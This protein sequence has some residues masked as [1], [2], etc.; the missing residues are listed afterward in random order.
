MYYQINPTETFRER[1]LAL[2]GEAEDWRR[3]RRRLRAPRARASCRPQT[4]RKE[5]EMTQAID[6]RTS[7][8]GW[9]RKTLLGACLMVVA[10]LLAAC[11]MG[12]QPAHASTT[13][14]VNSTGDDADVGPL[15]NVCDASRGGGECTLRAA[16]QQANA[17]S[18]AD[19]INFDIP[20]TGVQTIHVNATGFGA[21][22]AITEQVT[23]DG[24]T[25]AG[26]HPNT[27]AVGNDAALKIV[28]D[29]T[30][31]GGDGLRID[32]ASNSLIKGLVINS[33]ETSGI[34]I[35]GTTAVGTRIVGNFIG[36]DASGTL[37]KGNGLYGVVAYADDISQTVVGGTTP[38]ARNLISGNARNG[39]DMGSNL[40]NS[41][42]QSVRVQGNYIG[43]DRSGTK[44][45]GNSGDGIFLELASG[46]RV[47]GKTASSRNVVSGNAA[48][49][50]FYHVSGS[51]V[52]GNRIGTTVNGTGT[53]GND[54]YGV[55][56]ESSSN[57]ASNNKIGDGTAAGS[58]TIAFNGTD[59]V[60]I[61]SGLGNEVSRNSV[62]SNGGLGIDLLILPS[63]TSSTN[64]S[65]TN[66]P[67][68]ADSGANALQ[69]KPIL[70]SAKTSSLKT[71]IKGKLESIPAKSYTVEF[72]ANPS[73][74]NEGKKFIGETT[75]TTS[76]DGLQT[77]TFSPATKVP[78]GQTVTATATSATT[79]DTSEFS[80]PRTVAA[81]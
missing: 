24:Y 18:G 34:N 56:F 35:F 23:I 62:F 31:V 71:T 52:L 45:L 78:V 65:N 61:F 41:P 38:A 11:L 8:T 58:N 10:T 59:G 51:S 3:A 48:G 72:Y 20:G 47:G 70:S 67:L 2:L 63:E 28:L 19:T 14:T 42:A 80:A 77:F 6:T 54:Q 25:Q 22:P 5:R 17:T 33:F 49:V 60:E 50:D 57:T 76:V 30:L 46:A 55:H 43:T 39:V 40:L 26:A 53:L 27:L 21:L 9:I 36:T 4:G 7:G 68:D 74:T 75:F 16:I 15:D 32:G 66:D 79:H 37:D 81:S 1:H 69:N 73:N 64:V 29:G 12:A 44:D 13:F